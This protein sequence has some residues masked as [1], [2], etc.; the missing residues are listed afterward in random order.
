MTARVIMNQLRLTSI[1]VTGL[2]LLISIVFSGC[3]SL[4]PSADLVLKNG[5]IITLDGDNKVAQSVAVFEGRILAVGTDSEIAELQDDQTKVIDLDGS[6]VSPGFIE[7]HGHFLSL[8]KSLMRLRLNDAKTYDDIVVMVSEAAIKARPGEWILGRGWHQEKWDEV[9]NPNVDGLPLHDALSRVSPDNPVLLSHASG[10]AVMANAKAM[11]LAGIDHNTPNPEG[12]EI[13]RD[14]KGDPIGIF[15]E[16]ASDQLFL[17]LEEELS[18]KSRADEEEDFE[19]MVML[20]VNECLSKGVTSFHDAGTPLDTVLRFKEMIDN[21]EI[22]LRLYIML[23]DSNHIL[24]ERLGDARMIGYGND[25]LTVRSIKRSIDGALGSHG[26][27]L[28]EPYED[29]PTSRGLNTIDIEYLKET[30]RLASEFNFQLCVH[31]IGDRGNQ[32]ALDI[33]EKAYENS[34]ELDMRW[35]IEHA[36]HL[37]LDDIPRFAELG[38]I[39]AMQGVHCTS[40]GPWVPKR[41]GD[42]RAEEGAYVWRKLMESGAMICNGT[43]T[44]VEDVDPLA[45]FVSTVTRRMNNGDQF[46]PSQVM[47]RTEALRSYTVNAAYAAFEERDKGSITPG[48]LADIVVLSGDLL[49]LPEEELGGVKVLYTIIGGEVVY[50]AGE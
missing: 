5:K 15:R 10:H 33:Y 21:D 42:K 38:I 40:D 6:F 44:P 3:M 43:D 1:I 35:R 31:A 28:L 50:K 37:S 2:I 26:A 34:K 49:T 25:H 23:S 29:M 46:Y 12:G 18:Q 45:N 19:R 7:S 48:M 13:V 24:E 32:Q 9:P 41:I 14:A 20:A 16:N 22:A 30:A 17:A 8:G 36:Q 4:L 39:A 27:W 47:S 11:E